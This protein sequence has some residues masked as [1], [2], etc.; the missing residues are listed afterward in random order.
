MSAGDDS[1][2][3]S[4]TSGFLEGLLGAQNKDMA[5]A[6]EEKQAA[7]QALQKMRGRVP[8]AQ[9]NALVPAWNPANDAP[10]EALSPA[11]AGYMAT[12]RGQARNRSAEQIAQANRAMSK[13]IA[14]MKANPGATGA[15][16]NKWAVHYAQ[17]AL[18]AAGLTVEDP[19]GAELYQQTY[20][21]LSPDG[22]QQLFEEVPRDPS[23]WFPGAPKMKWRDPN[24]ESRFQTA[25]PPATGGALKKASPPKPAAKPG[26]LDNY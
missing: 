3:L 2:A 20:G 26:S 4:R 8:G 13:A 23:A 12:Q 7:R 25:A 24:F 9:M 18:K 11:V 6:D 1:G 16:A 19:E 15:N 5:R 17:Q 22:Y 21:L 10:E 14:D